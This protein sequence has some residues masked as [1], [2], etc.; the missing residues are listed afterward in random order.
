MIKLT[1]AILSFVSQLSAVEEGQDKDN[2]IEMVK[3]VSRITKTACG[4]DLFSPNKR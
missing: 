3:E 1:L 4:L 2:G